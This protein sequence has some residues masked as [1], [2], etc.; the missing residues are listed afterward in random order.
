MKFTIRKSTNFDAIEDIDEWIFY[1]CEPIL[2]DN[3]VL[4]VATATGGM[5]A[6][7]L[8]ANKVTEGVYYLSR[9]AVIEEFR[10]NQLQYR[11]QKRLEMDLRTAGEEMIIT[12]TL[13]NNVP[14]ANNMIK[15]G[16]KLYLPTHPWVGND[17]NYW[18]LKL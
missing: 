4:Y 5:I 9:V 1:G 17:V 18:L 7:Y 6:G 12:Y 10:G 8:L 16:Y 11:L 15:T 2:R 13:V 14:S 3:A